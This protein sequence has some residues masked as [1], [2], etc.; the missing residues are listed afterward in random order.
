MKYFWLKAIELDIEYKK[1]EIKDFLAQFDLLLDQDVEECIGL[2][3]GEIMAAVCCRSGKVLKGFAVKEE[4]RENNL[5]SLLVSDMLK[6][7][8]AAGIYKSFVFTKNKYRA[9]FESLGYRFLGQ[10]G[11]T[12]LLETGLNGVNEYL[13]K[14][15]ESRSEGTINGCIVMN[16]NPFTLGHRYLVDRA[17]TLC[18]KLYIILVQEDKSS[19]P[20][21]VRKELVLQGTND[22]LNVEVIDGGDYTISSA[23]FPGY[24]IR[25]ENEKIFSEAALDI[26][27]FIRYTAPALGIVKRFAGSEPYDAVTAVYNQVMREKLPQA[28]IEFI[29][30]E[31]LKAEGRYI[32]ASDVRRAI[33]EKKPL[34]LQKLVPESTL[35]FLLSTE[36]KILWEK[37]SNNILSH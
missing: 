26:D 21:M 33:R 32:S 29:E 4:Y 9:K 24:F 17:S 18:E 31:R 16:C 13:S 1:K 22:L 11:E 5:T 7:L 20:Y 19:F 28:G 25:Q 23:T 37:I 14:H 12:I 2:Y 34:L 27:L 10:G 30:I 6:R 35:A 36:G 8:Y 15:K 3:D